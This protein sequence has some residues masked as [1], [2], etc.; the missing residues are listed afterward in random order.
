[1]MP[2]IVILL[3]RFVSGFGET[4]KDKITFSSLQ[5]YLNGHS[6]KS[7]PAKTPSAAAA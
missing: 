5:F 6:A 4:S 3:E 2:F 7:T 1:M